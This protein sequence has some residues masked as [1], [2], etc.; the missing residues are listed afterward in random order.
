[1]GLLNKLTTTGTTLNPNG[2]NTPP[3]PVGATDQSKLQYEY[4]INGMPNIPFNGYFTH[5]AIKPSPSV[6]DLNG[7]NPLGPLRDITIPPINNSFSCG[8]YKNC[9]PEGASF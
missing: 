7:V 6:L 1:M 5:Y 2:V 4:S 9:T 8:V 3:I